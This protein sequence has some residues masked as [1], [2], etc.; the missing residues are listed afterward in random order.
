MKYGMNLLLWTAELKED[1]LPTLEA[2]KQY[3][4]DG[5]EVPVF[6]ADVDNDARWGKRLDDLGLERT[7]VTVRNAEDNPISPDHAIRKQ[8]VENNKRVVDSCHAMGATAL[9]GPFHSALGVFTGRGPT[10]D[11]W[12]WGVD[13]TRQIAHHAGSAEVTL[14][15]EPLNRFES[16]LLNS[17]SDAARLVREV[18]HTHCRVL[19]DT[20]HANIH[21]FVCCGQ[22]IWWAASPWGAKL[23]R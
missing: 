19:Y 8:G 20:F 4:F 13:S 15:V 23:V 6:H 22:P 21:L 18:D 2:L 17:A 7:V 10:E 1:L 16:Y 3:G 9:V 12:K 14:C 11:E 5:V